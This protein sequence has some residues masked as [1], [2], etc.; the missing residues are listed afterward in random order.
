MVT[1]WLSI[2]GMQQQSGV[3]GS[4]KQCLSLGILLDWALLVLNAS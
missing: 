3:S 2:A 1:A 4:C